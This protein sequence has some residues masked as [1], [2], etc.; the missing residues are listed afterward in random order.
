MTKSV[1]I[2]HTKYLNQLKKTLKCL[3]S[4]KNLS[5]DEPEI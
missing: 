4:V 1:K 3:K 5:S 2:F